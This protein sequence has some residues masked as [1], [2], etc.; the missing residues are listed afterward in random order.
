MDRNKMRKQ[1]QVLRNKKLK[2]R[3][4]RI[5]APKIKPQVKNK[6]LKIETFGTK[7]STSTKV[8]ANRP[9]AKQTPQETRLQRRVSRPQRGGCPGCR[10]RLGS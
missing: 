8:A 6:V 10:R 4:Q 1:L 9:V 3:A 2:P 7:Q 5:R